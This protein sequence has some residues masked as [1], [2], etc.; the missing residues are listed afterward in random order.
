MSLLSE[1]EEEEETVVRQLMGDDCDKMFAKC[2]KAI[3]DE[4]EAVDCSSD[5]KITCLKKM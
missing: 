3:E 5:N 4:F 2:L 1:D